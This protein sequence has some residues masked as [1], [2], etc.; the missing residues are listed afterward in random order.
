MKTILLCVAFL[1][2][3]MILSGCGTVSEVTPTAGKD[4]DLRKYDRVLV[5][6]FADGVIDKVRPGAQA[7]KKAEMAI[8]TKSFP[9]RIAIALGE[10]NVFKEVARTGSPDSQTLIISGTI[11]RYTE[12][13]AIGRLLIGLGAGSSYFDATVDF[14]DG[15]TSD[16]LANQKIDKNSWVLGGGI[17]A[18][19]TPDEF[20]QEA[21]E[22][23][24]EDL[25][26]AKLTGKLPERVS[27]PPARTGHR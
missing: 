1:G 9:D 19:Q 16:I 27:P 14:K 18:T 3:G 26:T 10:K 2:L 25:S 4:L 20:M 17:A 15:T 13:D 23:L 8:R 21:A 7:K 12:G 24:A 5:L 11:T 22:V 6:D